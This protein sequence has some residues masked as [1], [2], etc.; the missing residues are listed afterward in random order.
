MVYPVYNTSTRVL[1]P[2]RAVAGAALL[3]AAATARNQAFIVIVLTKENK[4]KMLYF[5]SM[6]SLFLNYE[7][8]AYKNCPA[9][10]WRPTRKYIRMPKTTCV[11]KLMGTST[12]VSARPSTKG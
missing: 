1:R 5:V 12:K 3:N 4:K 6:L 9:D 10:C 8:D 7:S 11:T 2:P